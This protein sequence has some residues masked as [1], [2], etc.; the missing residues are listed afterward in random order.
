MTERRPDTIEQEL[1]ADLEAGIAVDRAT[2][3]GPDTGRL[4][5]FSDGVF[6]IA[7]TLLA[8]NIN[9]PSL[10][11]NAGTATQIQSI[12]GLREPVMVYVQSFIIVGNYWVGHHRMFQLIRAW[13]MPLVWLNLLFLM[14]VAFIPVPSAVMIEHAS[15]LPAIIFFLSTAI[16]TGLLD[17]AIWLYAVKQRLLRRPVSRRVVRYMTTRSALPVVLFALGIAAAFV[18]TQLVWVIVIAT[19]VSSTGLGP[20]YDR[21]SRRRIGAAQRSTSLPD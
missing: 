21:F 20:L 11:D 1:T 15:A 6:A 4:L 19:V 2:G 3:R 14:L 5:A 8:L 18:S 17:L 7:I 10:S 9:I 12:L 13:D 16:L